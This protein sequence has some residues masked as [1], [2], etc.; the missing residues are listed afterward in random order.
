MNEDE[1]IEKMIWSFDGAG[2]DVGRK[3]VDNCW[4]KYGFSGIKLS[5]KIW[6][7]RKYAR[8]TTQEHRTFGIEW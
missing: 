7:E 3:N 2:I 6:D 8:K 1:M 4:M 5:S